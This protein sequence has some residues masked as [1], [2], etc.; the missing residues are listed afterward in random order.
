MFN[1]DME[2]LED[3]FK[4]HAKEASKRQIEQIDRWKNEYSSVDLPEHLKDTFFLSSALL[5][6]VRELQRLRYE[7]E[8]IRDR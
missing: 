3:V 2:N 1:Y 6:M 7:I 8:E 4:K 5:Y